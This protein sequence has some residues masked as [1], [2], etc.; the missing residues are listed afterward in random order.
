M[1]LDFNGMLIMHNLVEL[2]ANG[3]TDNAQSRE[4]LFPMNTVAG[5]INLYISKNI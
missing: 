3:R 4:G 2:G 1:S 5:M